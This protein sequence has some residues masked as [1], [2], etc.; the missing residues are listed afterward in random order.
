MM[1]NGR[2]TFELTIFACPG[3]T[4]V[5]DASVAGLLGILSYMAQYLY[6]RSGLG[7][8]Y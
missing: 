7:I 8:D 4:F 5:E 6:A 2:N 3:A 1:S